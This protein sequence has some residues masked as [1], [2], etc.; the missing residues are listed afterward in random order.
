MVAVD[1]ENNTL[2]EIDLETGHT[3]SSYSLGIPYFFIHFRFIIFFGKWE[4]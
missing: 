2:I 4:G 3:I 1:T